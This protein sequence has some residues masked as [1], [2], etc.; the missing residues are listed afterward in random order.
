MSLKKDGVFLDADLIAFD[1]ATGSLII[2]IPSAKTSDAGDYSLT[3]KSP[4]GK[5]TANFDVIVTGKKKK[6]ETKIES[7]ITTTEEDAT[8]E[9]LVTMEITEDDEKFKKQKGLGPKF[10]LLPEPQIVSEG[11]SVRITCAISGDPEPEVT[12][13]KEGS[14]IE[15]DKTMTIFPDDALLVMEIKECRMENAGKYKIQAENEH[16]TAKANFN[17]IVKAR[18]LSKAV[19]SEIEFAATDGILNAESSSVENTE[20]TDKVTARVKVSEPQI[21]VVEEKPRWKRKGATTPQF[22]G[23]G[24]MESV[25]MGENVHMEI[26]L[27]GWINCMI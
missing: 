16:G 13:F 8:V 14:V 22:E 4:S 1:E 15:S 26:M 5:S 17:L 2:T 12:W 24:E 9:E 11:K 19:E 6:K 7:E 20:V 18:E 3:L 23:K 21:R 10:D 27:K 25:A